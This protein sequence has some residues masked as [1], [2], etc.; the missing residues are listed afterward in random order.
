ML[1][2]Q[3][4]IRESVQSNIKIQINVANVPLVIWFAAEKSYNGLK[5]VSVV[6][7]V[8]SVEC[9]CSMCEQIE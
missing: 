4:L 6:W 5:C 2:I 1:K 8:C 9:V 3:R 7:N